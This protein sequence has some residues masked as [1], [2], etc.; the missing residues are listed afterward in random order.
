MQDAIQEVVDYKAAVR[1]AESLWEIATSGT[2]P[3]WHNCPK[4]GVKIKLDRVDLMAKVN[5]QGQ[6]LSQ[7]WGKPK[8]DE[9]SRGF[10][11]NRVIV[12]PNEGIVEPMGVE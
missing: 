5:A 12:E 1:N 10:I 11:L 8:D 2:K 3:E 4:C 9:D 7:G 6:L